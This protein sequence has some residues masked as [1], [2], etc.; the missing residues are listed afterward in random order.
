MDT[1]TRPFGASF[2]LHPTPPAEVVTHPRTSG[3]EERMLMQAFEEFAG[4]RKSGRTS[5]RWKREVV[6]SAL[7]LFHKA[8]ELGIFMAEVPEEYGGLDLN[9]LA[10]T[11]M[12]SIRSKLGSLGLPDLRPSGD[13]HAAADQLRDRGA[14]G[15][16][17]RAVHER[18]D[19]VGVRAHGAEHRLGRDEHHHARRAERRRHA[20]RRQR[21]QAVD[22]ET[23]TGRTS[24]SSSRRSTASTSRRSSWT[25]TARGSRSERTSGCSGQ[26]G[27]SVA[28]LSLDNVRIPGG[29]TCSER[30]GRGTSSR[31]A[32]STWGG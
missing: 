25:A 26:H 17:P 28:A 21:R 20:L 24:S 15:P 29:T 5:T 32:R 14:A 3:E 11:G 13:R 30:S 2:L 18:R 31:S 22:H 12:C 23:R 19:A 8:A 9:V 7:E 4:A 16:L 6:R 1:A 27:S 10:V